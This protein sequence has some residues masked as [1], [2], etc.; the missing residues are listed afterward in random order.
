MEHAMNFQEIDPFVRY[1]QFLTITSNQQYEN[2]ASYDYRLFYCS[3]GMGTILVDGYSYSMKTGCAALWAPGLE[4]SLHLTGGSKHV[5]L[6]G[7]NFDYTRHHANLSTPV[8]PAKWRNFQLENIIEKVVFSDCTELNSPVHITELQTLRSPL[9]QLTSEYIAQKP[10][11]DCKISGLLKSTLSTIARSASCS[12][13][14]TKGELLADKVIQYI[15]S[16]YRDDITNKSLGALFGYHPNH[17]NRIVVQQTGMSIHHYLIHCRLNAAIELLQA[18]D[19]KANEIAAAVGFKDVSHFLKYF[20][21]ATGK[22]TRDF[23]K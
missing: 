10:F 12:S 23:R 18:S 9:Y 11:F 6:I 16:H 2:I 17:L 3:G 7:I 15:H 1:A 14:A 21:K 13:G 8:P 5:D 19:I 22:T 20:K 4:Y